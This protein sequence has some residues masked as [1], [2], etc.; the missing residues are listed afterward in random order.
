[1]GGVARKQ[2]EDISGGESEDDILEIGPLVGPGDKEGPSRVVTPRFSPSPPLRSF[3]SINPRKSQRTEILSSVR[4]LSSPSS[5]PLRHLASF[6]F[7]PVVLNVS[8]FRFPFALL[9][10]SRVPSS[11]CV[12][13]L[14][15][16][17]CHVLCRQARTSPARC[18][19]IP[20]SPSATPSVV[21]WLTLPSFPSQTWLLSVLTLTMTESINP[22]SP[23]RTLFNRN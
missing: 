13:L 18:P 10:F 15:A 14:D 23:P 20:S 5:P 22:P 16:N 21:H 7:L 1:M 4:L 9:P 19:F 6:S 2:N 3:L 17:C 11:F 8:P 12:L